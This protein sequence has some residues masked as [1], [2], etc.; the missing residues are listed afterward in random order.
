MM[1][2]RS[3][4]FLLLAAAVALAQAPAPAAPKDAIRNGGFEST[5]QAPN[6]SSGVDKDGFL[7]GLRGFLPVLN[8]S[9]NVAQT[10][11]PVGETLAEVPHWI[12]GSSEE[13]NTASNP[14]AHWK[15]WKPSASYR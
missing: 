6:L 2:P 9:G 12:D 3:V 11:M 4:A 13:A 15:T 10:S 5:L 8:E 1:F 7:A 14:K